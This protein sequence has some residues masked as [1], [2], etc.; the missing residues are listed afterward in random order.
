MELSTGLSSNVCG[1]LPVV[2]CPPGMMV[3]NRPKKVGFGKQ[4]KVTELDRT[5]DV[6]VSYT[7]SYVNPPFSSP[8]Y[9][10]K[11]QGNEV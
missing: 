9:L 4:G 5:F 7:K 3:P 6:T 8:E 2:A 1:A 11:E 10:K